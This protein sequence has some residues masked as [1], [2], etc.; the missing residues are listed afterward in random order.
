MNP[1]AFHMSSWFVAADTNIPCFNQ[2]VSESNRIFHISCLN[3]TIYSDGH[4]V[5]CAFGIS[6]V[7]SKLLVTKTHYTKFWTYFPIFCFLF[8]LLF[9]IVIIHYN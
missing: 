3:I 1:H 6:A 5:H 9:S 8:P 7:P 2:S 4:G